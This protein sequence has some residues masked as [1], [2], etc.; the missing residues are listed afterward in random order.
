MQRS[1]YAKD[2]DAIDMNGSEMFRGRQRRYQCNCGPRSILL[3]RKCSPAEL[4]YA[5]VARSWMKFGPTRN[6]TDD[7][8][9][10][11]M[12]SVSMFAHS[13]AGHQGQG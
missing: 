10:D 11:A 2:N 13:S 3:Y 1:D 12:G 8:N 5:M 4:I 7:I 9:E 6:P